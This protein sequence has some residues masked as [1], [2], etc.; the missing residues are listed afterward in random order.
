MKTPPTLVTRLLC[1]LALLGANIASGVDKPPHIAAF[2]KPAAGSLQM[3]FHG[4]NGPYLVQCRSSLDPNAPWKDLPTA[5]VT[6]VQTGVYT[7]FVPDATGSDLSFYRV[8]NEGDAGAETDAWTVLLN[9]SPPANGVYYAAGEAPTVT[10]TILDTMGT[11]LSRVDFSTLS[12]YMYGP[13]DP[14]LTKTASKLLKASTDRKASVHHYIN[15]LNNPGVQ[16][17]GNVLTYPLAAVSD[18][19]PGTYTV[20]LYAVRASNPLEQLMKFANAQIGNN[21]VEAPVVTKS[22]SCAACHEGPIS[23]KIYMH[24]I[25]PGRSPTGSWAMDYQPVTSCKS[26]HNNDGYAAYTDATG[27]KIPDNIVFRV[28]G[29]HMGEELQTAAN[30]NPTNGIFKNYTEVVF[31]A[32]VRNCTKCHVDDRWKTKPSR[33]ACGTC[34]DNVWFGPQPGPGGDYVDHEGGQQ[35]TDMN[36][37]SCHGADKTPLQQYS[38]ISENHKIA[39]S[40]MDNIDVTLSPPANGTNYVAGEKPTVTLVIRDDYG[41]PVDHTKV[42]DGNYS[43]ASLFVYGPRAKAVPVLTSAAR[44]VNSKLRASVTSSKAGPWAINGKVFKVAVNG[45]APQNITIVGA[46][47]MVTAAEVVTSLNAV[48]VPLNAK[49]TVSGANVNMKTTIQ[50]SQARFEIYDGEVTAAMGWKRA[51]NTITD[52][53][54]TIAAGSTPSNDLR[55]LSD[56]LDYADPM[57]KRNTTNIVYQLDDVAGLAAGTYSIYVYQLPKAGKVANMAAPTGIGFA[58]FQIGTGTKE[59]KIAGGCKDCHGD[60]IWHLAEGPIHAEPFDTDYCTAC[61]DYGHNAPGDM[62]KNQGGTSLNGWSGYGAMPISRRVHGVHKGAYLEHPEEIYANATK[63][64]FG[65]IIFPQDLRNCTKCHNDG[66][67]TWKENASRITC[68][69]CHDSDEAKAHGKIMTFMGDPADPYGPFS[70]ETCVVCHGK[71]RDFSPDK[72]HSIKDP[73]VP[74]YPRE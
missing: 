34:H 36:C 12:L 69:A 23:G 62:F 53:D 9:V 66:N 71:D 52:P 8:L 24:H 57:V 41:N 48:I 22:Q 18:E 55:G 74:P 17:N 60:T 40:N 33:L 10:V 44:N 46:T 14:L 13:Q 32:D 50:G 6:E 64:T 4:S 16:V 39:P 49:A 59:K 45:S 21:V 72:L 65:H 29:V 19:Q 43:T 56:P 35:I 30:T 51:P 7:A 3:L 26:C 31:P 28:H 73:Y 61:H 47:D 1:V 20:T 67:T 70:Y 38:S 68:L 15:L 2:S 37:S 54:I 42:T 27:A 58:S 5:V 63:D 25:D 11:G